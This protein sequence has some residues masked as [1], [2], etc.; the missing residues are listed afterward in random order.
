MMMN[1]R[2][3]SNLP[4][5][6]L[7]IAATALL[8]FGVLTAAE[9]TPATRADDFVDSIGV[10][11]H[12][13]YTDTIYWDFEK[14]KA[15]LK[16]L[17][18]RHVR[19]G[20]VYNARKEYYERYGELA[21]AGVK[22]TFIVSGNLSKLSEQAAKLRP[23]IDA[24]EGPNEANLNRW[25]PEDA[26][27]Y[28][29]ALW[30]T[31]KADESL[32]ALPVIGLSYTDQGYGAK[33][34][35]LSDAMDFGNGHPYPGGW[36]PENGC[37]WMKADLPSGLGCAA[38]LREEAGHVHRDRLYQRHQSHGRACACQRGRGRSLSAAA[39]P[40]LLSAGR[41]ANILV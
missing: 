33:L 37:N 31:V 21:A 35:D 7:C 17:G 3:A 30:K 29:L 18:I 6:G 4:V 15:A 9:P 25:K 23:A 2:S 1:V 34:G 10:N 12:V 19:D 8:G 14:L 22:A 40:Q 5:F 38:D 41:G 13:H 11:V 32:R 24:I 20:L 39:L 27:A 16:D 28:Q 36:E 26:R